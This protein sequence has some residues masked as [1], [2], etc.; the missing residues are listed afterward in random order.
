MTCG[1]QKTTG[2]KKKVQNG[3]TGSKNSRDTY[4]WALNRVLCAWLNR[5][6]VN[7]TLRLSQS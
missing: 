3:S 6:E 5:E 1:E 2:R 4:L 7:S